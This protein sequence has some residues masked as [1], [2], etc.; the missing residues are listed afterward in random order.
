MNH[1]ERG[2]GGEERCC[3]GGEKEK[4]EGERHKCAP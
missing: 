3:S 1:F 4:E 2:K